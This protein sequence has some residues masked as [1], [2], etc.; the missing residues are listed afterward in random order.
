MNRQLLP[1]GNT[2][3]A[4]VFQDAISTFLMDFVYKK[5]GWHDISAGTAGWALTRAYFEFLDGRDV[6]NIKTDLVAWFNINK[7]STL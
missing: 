1:I 6:D 5:K 3:E 2:P 4:I 7:D